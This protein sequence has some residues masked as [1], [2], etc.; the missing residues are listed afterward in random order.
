MR[1]SILKTPEEVPQP[2]ADL[3]FSG[4]RMTRGV[5]ADVRWPK[6][7]PPE[8]LERLCD[9]PWTRKHSYGYVRDG[10]GELWKIEELEFDKTARKVTALILIPISE[11]RKIS[12]YCKCGA[13]MAGSVQA[14][15]GKAVDKCVEL[16][17]SVH[18]KPGCGA[19]NAGSAAR[20]RRKSETKATKE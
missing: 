16:F 15:N 1:C 14:K 7:K 18:Q 20:A 9:A 11:N 2:N 3:D 19:T 10:E 6:G 4:R 12:A 5:V 13:A 17:W 8:A